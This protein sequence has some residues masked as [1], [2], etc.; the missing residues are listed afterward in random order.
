M[1]NHPLVNLLIIFLRTT[2]P[3]STR[4][5]MKLPICLLVDNGSLRPE[6]VLTMRRVAQKLNCLS[7]YEVIPVSL[8]HSNK[9]DPSELNDKNG[10]TIETFLAGH[11]GK[12]DRPLLVLPFFFGPSRGITEWLIEKLMAWGQKDPDRTFKVLDTLYLGNEKK[13]ARALHEQIAG[14]ELKHNLNAPH[15]A[16]VDHGT[17]VHA[18]NQVRESVGTELS[19]LISDTNSAF[20][21]CSME[22][23][24][25]DEYAFN[26]PL[27]EQVLEKWGVN[28]VGYVVLSMFFLLPGRHAGKD[29]DL[30][31]ICTNAVKKFPKMKIFKTEPLGEDKIIFEI[32]MQKLNTELSKQ[33]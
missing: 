9:I 6:A 29:G 4:K 17:P 32:L 21:T 7:A 19:S 24:E 1:I 16:M 25:G 2:V 10:E 23:R 13:L 11:N 33:Q 5:R 15:V 30:D 22:R 3:S 18:V 28:G 12:D 31:E 8:L 27:L 20:S 14:V 26:D